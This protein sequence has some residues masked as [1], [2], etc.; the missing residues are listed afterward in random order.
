MKKLAC[1]FMAFAL[2]LIYLPARAPS[3][4]AAALLTA[5]ESGEPQPPQDETGSAADAEPIKLPAA[6][7]VT[8]TDVPVPTYV[9]VLIGTGDTA[10]LAEG[11]RIMYR[12]DEGEWTEYSGSLA[13]DI[14]CVISA[15]VVLAD[16]TESEVSSTEVGCIDKYPPEPPQIFAD[17]VTWVN[18]FVDVSVVSG[19]DAE[20]GVL[21]NEYR[22]GEEGQWIEYTAP[23]SV[24]SPIVFYARTIDRA[25]NA[26]TLSSAE[27][28]NFDTTAPDVGGLIVTFTSETAPVT[29]DSI[30][31]QY[32]S[33]NVSFSIDGARDSQSGVAEYHYQLAGSSDT[34]SADGWIEYDPNEHPI[35]K[36]SFCGYVF[37]RA[38]DN[39]GNISAAAPSAAIVIDTEAPVVAGIRMNPVEITDGR[40]IVTFD[41]TDNF[42][43]DKV[44]VGDS[45]LGTYDPTFTAFRNGDYTLTAIDKAGNSTQVVFTISNID[46]TPFSLLSLF[47]QLD[48]DSFTPSTWVGVAAAADELQRIITVETNPLLVQAAAERLVASMEGLVSRGDGTMSLELIDRVLEYDPAKYTS[49]SWQ[50]VEIRIADIRL[51]LDDPES[52]QA[53]VDTV[54]RALEQAVSELTMLGNFTSLDRLIAQCETIGGDRYDPV[55]Y[56]V[57]TE[58]LAAA[59][60]LSRTDSSQ[61]DVDT[62]YSALLQA[63]DALRLPEE[64][65]EPTLPVVGY[66]IIGL[67]VVFILTVLFIIF[68]S[69]PT[70]TD[71][72]PNEDSEDDFEDD[73]DESQD[74]PVY[75]IGDICFSD[76][77]NEQP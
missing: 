66:V 69:R 23:V 44:M 76:S 29:A 33:G 40:V 50:R 60:A 63:M 43:L 46:S 53:D 31:G 4:G 15:K 72:L 48:E 73:F 9:E 30:F 22:L 65:P 27:I 35:I 26:S 21:R 49:S 64:E 16:G 61:R 47:E 12:I 52:T 67:L 62:A 42:W 32:Y 54:R 14:N 25:G 37:V 5:E 38:V 74:E 19:S 68:K 56:G 75:T 1:I 34:L 24:T 20:S 55:K 28:Y 59:K 39:A 6:P 36:G 41:I 7:V 13:I 8:F 10:A 51:C 71:E 2:L 70:G 17:T 11:D 45:Y 77:D 18:D 57:F 3:V 58:V